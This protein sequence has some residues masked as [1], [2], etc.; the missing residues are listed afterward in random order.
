MAL[1]TWRGKPQ[2]LMQVTGAHAKAKLLVVPSLTSATL[3][4]MVLR[5]AA[6]LS[7]PVGQRDTKVFE[8]ADLVVRSAE[9]ESASWAHQ[10][11]DGAAT[12]A[13]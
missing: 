13:P 8:V 4:L 10:K 3:G 2:R 1:P 6:H 5:R 9:V 11:V 7:I 12:P